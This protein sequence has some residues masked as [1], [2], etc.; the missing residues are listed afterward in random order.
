MSLTILTENRFNQKDWTNQ[1]I[2]LKHNR[3]TLFGEQTKTNA[4]TN[5]RKNIQFKNFHSWFMNIEQLQ[6]VFRVKVYTT[7][8]VEILPRIKQINGPVAEI[9][10]IFC[11]KI[12]QKMC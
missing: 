11:N 1:A 2:T 4:L 7:N 5:N 3:Y 8:T 12:Y 10:K 6:L 9:D